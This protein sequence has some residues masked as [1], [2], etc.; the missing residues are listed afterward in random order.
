MSNGGPS[1]TALLGLL[2][3]AGYQNRDK[4]GEW[5]GGLTGGSAAAQPQPQPQQSLPPSQ[6]TGSA[7]TRPP[8]L[9]S[10]LAGLGPQ[11][12]N[13]GSFLGGALSNLVDRFQQA[14]HGPVAQS[15]VGSGPNTPIAPPDLERAIGPDTLSALQ[16]QTGLSRDEILSRLSRDLPSA[17]DRYTPDGRLPSAT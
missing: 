8:A 5:I 1:M 7:G 3:V 10:I 15:W 17:V 12:A 9:E 2:A 13:P 16:S 11:G 4:I 14:G 6:G